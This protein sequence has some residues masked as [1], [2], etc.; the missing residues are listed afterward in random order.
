MVATDDTRAT[1]RRVALELFVTQ[2][3][4]RTSLRHIAERLGF[5]KA[6]LYY[7]YPSKAELIR[8]IVQPLVDDTN[9]ALDAF[10]AEAPVPPHDLLARW[11]EVLDEHRAIFAALTRDASGLAHVD[12]EEWSLRLVDRLQRLLVGEDASLEQRV[13][14]QVAIA[15]ASRVGFLEGSSDRA[16]VR[17]AVVVA[18]GDVL[19][20]RTTEQP[21]AHDA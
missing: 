9:D 5:T 2:G 15:G 21:G 18:C 7:H 11:F 16:R 20:P 4:E 19:G 12:L 14:A 3:F 10:E 6:A 1:I 13:R 17:D 8:S